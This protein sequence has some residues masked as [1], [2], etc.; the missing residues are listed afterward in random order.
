MDINLNL[1]LRT[2]EAGI[3][4][5]R[6]VPKESE[7]HFVSTSLSSVT[8]KAHIYIDRA[9]LLSQAIKLTGCSWGR[10]NTSV[11]IYEV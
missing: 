6:E 8:Q 10:R 3:S 9:S 11:I 2:Q 4:L 1:Y 7:F 5:V